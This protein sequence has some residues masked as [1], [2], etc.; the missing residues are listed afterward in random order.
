MIPAKIRDVDGNRLIIKGDSDVRDHMVDWRC[1]RVTDR[2]N[3]ITNREK[4]AIPWF[5][6]VKLVP[7]IVSLSKQ[8]LQ[9]TKTAQSTVA[10]PLEER[11]A[12]LEVNERNQAELVAS[13]AQQLAAMTDALTV[14]RKQ[15]STFRLISIISSLLAIAAIIVALV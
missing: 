15:V 12:E 13:M 14:L 6:I 9:Q 7:E 8:L 11:V 1:L 5:Q 2:S 3:P 10:K 4:M